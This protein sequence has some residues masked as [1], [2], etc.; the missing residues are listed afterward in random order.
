[1]VTKPCLIMYTKLLTGTL[2][3]TSLLS[4]CGGGNST[5]GTASDTTAATPADSA[6]SLAKP[7]VE[8]TKLWETD[9]TLTTCESV[10]YD[11]KRGTIYV[12]CMNG[13]ADK[14]DGNGYIAKLTPEGKIETVQWAAG[15]DAPKGMGILGDKLYVTDIDQLVEIDI[16][17]AKVAKKHPVKGAKFLNDITVS[18]NTVFFTDMNANKIHQFAPGGKLA[19]F[20]ADTTLGTPN[21]LYFDSTS[22][23][24]YLATFGDQRFKKIDLASKKIENLTDGIE[25]GDGVVNLGQGDFLVSSWGGRVRYI[26]TD[27]QATEVLNTIAQGESAADIWYIPE[28]KLLL[29]PTFFKN[30]VT[31]YRVT[32]N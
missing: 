29:V 24:L 27:R 26:G 1:M 23:S 12:A 16:P 31:A 10:I 9:T 5:T 8:L 11:A 13:E 21:G 32:V 18:A 28:Q 3:L 14:K 7:K 22:Q 17:T 30:K 2:L 19:E 15:L 4:A 20:L 25:Q 6:V